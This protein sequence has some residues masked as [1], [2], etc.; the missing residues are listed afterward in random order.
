MDDVRIY[1]FT[2]TADQVENIASPQTDLHSQIQVSGLQ[3]ETPN[4]GLTGGK[5]E[6][7]VK[8]SFDVLHT[9]STVLTGDDNA[10][11]S[12]DSGD[13]TINAAKGVISTV[14]HP[15]TANTNILSVT[16]P[17]VSSSAQNADIG[18][19]KIPVVS[20]ALIANNGVTSRATPI[21]D[22]TLLDAKAQAVRYVLFTHSIGGSSG[23]AE[24]RGND[25]IIALGDGFDENNADHAGTEGDLQEVS[26]TYM[27]EI[28]HLLN[29]NHGGPRYL[30]NDPNTTL[31]ITDTNCVPIHRSIMSYTGQFPT[32]L[33][34]DWELTFNEL[35]RT[36][37]DDTVIDAHTLSEESLDEPLGVT[38]AG[39]P[40][41]VY[42]TPKSTSSDDLLVTA[43]GA[44]DWNG[45]LDFVD[46]A[47]YTDS[48]TNSKSD[49]AAF[50]INNFGIPGCGA[51]PG[52]DFEIF[53]EPANFDFKFQQGPYGQFDGANPHT[54]GDKHWK[55]HRQ[56]VLL[57]SEYLILPP[58]NIDGTDYVKLGST[59]P[60]KFKLFE[61]ITDLN[62]PIK[63]LNDRDIEAHLY[64]LD[65]NGDPQF[66]SV[67]GVFEKPTETTDHYQ[68]NWKSDRGA[69][70]L[71]GEDVGVVFVMNEND[72]PSGGIIQ[73]ELVENAAD[74]PAPILLLGENVDAE[75]RKVSV[76]I[77]FKQK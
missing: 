66:D 62:D 73:K 53:N 72:I 27:H 6:A 64:T 77:S 21:A 38:L 20:D 33:G 32:F 4:T 42:A 10:K 17:I 75:K 46:V 41:I 12:L 26:G 49:P 68:F 71:L 8:L 36:N 58:L 23:N 54:V 40:K 37:S 52:E 11:L 55:Q 7:N 30:L 25:A 34:T 28:G 14:K 5:T 29:M 51:S 48:P 18:T 19:L 76:L 56:E 67:L 24:L 16:A 63:F 70:D 69:T 47:P 9:A 22:S 61:K 57:N 45:D 3:L 43:N 59:I 2:L 44:M 74:V 35:G 60:L 65:A 31:A 13:F 15:I 1:N 50:D 39:P